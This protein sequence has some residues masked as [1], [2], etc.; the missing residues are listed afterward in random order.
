MKVGI[1]SQ[2]FPPEPVY[3]P[4]DLAEELVEHGHDVRVL[5]GF[6]NYPDGKVYPG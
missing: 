6:P 2:W 1:V 3:L 5:T 4:G